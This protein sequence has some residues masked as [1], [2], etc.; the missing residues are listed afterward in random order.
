MFCPCSGM[1]ADDHAD[2]KLRGFSPM[3]NRSFNEIQTLAVP[4]NSRLRWA[5]F[6]L[7]EFVARLL[8]GSRQHPRF[9]VTGHNTPCFFG[10]SM[11]FLEFLRNRPYA[12]EPP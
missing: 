9:G 12:E 1:Q 4:R 3:I 5:S 2:F 8:G 6:A 10:D 11:G 7:K